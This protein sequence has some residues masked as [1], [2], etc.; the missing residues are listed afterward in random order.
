MRFTELTK[1]KKLY[2]TPD[3]VAEKL[4]ISRNSAH[5]TCSRYVDSGVLLRLKRN[6]YAIQERWNHLSGENAFLVANILEVPSYIS[7]TTALSF[8]E[9]TTQVQR[10]FYESISIKRTKEIVAG[11][12]TFTFTKVKKELYGGFERKNGY[13]IAT[14]E[15]ALLDALYLMSLKR[16]RLDLDAV[17]FS[18]VNKKKIEEKI[19]AYPPKV[20]EIWRK[21]VGSV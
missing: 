9:I 12:R 8:Y 6:F 3:D 14:E 16:Y 7:L 13:F 11:D 5:V 15:K 2:F 17:D 20:R 1:I 21:H 10:D 18:K 4:G 19:K